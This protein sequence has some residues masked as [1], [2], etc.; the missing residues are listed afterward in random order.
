MRDLS[1]RRASHSPLILFALF[2]P[3]P[4]TCHPLPPPPFPLP[5]INHTIGGLKYCTFC[6]SIQAN[7]PIQRNTAVTCNCVH[8][9]RSLIMLLHMLP[10]PFQAACS[11]LEASRSCQPRVL[12]RLVEEAFRFAH[13]WPP[14]LPSHSPP[15]PCHPPQPQPQPLALALA[16]RQPA[17]VRVAWVGLPHTLSRSFT[18]SAE[19]SVFKISSP[20]ISYMEAAVTGPTPFSMPPPKYLRDEIRV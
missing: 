18:A 19:S 14:T 1:S 2:V 13:G 17:N 3:I 10:N 11:C 15:Y 6:W 4:W 7:V 16:H 20:N 9:K 5:L 12:A 8:P